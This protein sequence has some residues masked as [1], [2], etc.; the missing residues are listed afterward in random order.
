MLDWFNA[1]AAGVLACAA[2]WAVM[3]PHVRIGLLM[4][5]GLVFVAVGFLGV[6]LIALDPLAY[7]AAVKAANAIVHVGLVL[8]AV[9]YLQ[10]CHRRGPQRRASDWVERRR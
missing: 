7:H 3:S 2:G 10:R 6:F 4:H 9:G 1:A 5:L 8:C